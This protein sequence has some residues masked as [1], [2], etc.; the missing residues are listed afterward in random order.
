ML[1]KNHSH[2]DQV[3]RL[4]PINVVGNSWV[5]I[6]WLRLCSWRLH[7]GCQPSLHAYA[8]PIPAPQRADAPT[9]A[10]RCRQSLRRW[11]LFDRL[12]SQRKTAGSDTWGQAKARSEVV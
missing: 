4:I 1:R 10:N 7:G 3:Q 6:A 9:P 12:S 2:K 5:L 8:L 11:D